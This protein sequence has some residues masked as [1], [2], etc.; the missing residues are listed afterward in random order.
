MATRGYRCV[1]SIAA[2]DDSVTPDAV[3]A[4]LGAMGSAT[5]LELARRGVNV[6]GIDRYAPPH[7]FGSS[8]GKSRIIREAYFEDPRYVPLVQRAYERWTELEAES[9]VKLLHRT[10]GLML[11]PPDGTLVRG[12]RLSA[13]RHKLPHEVLSAADVRRRVP[14]FEPRGDMVGVWEPRA[15]AL[16]PELAIET[17]LKLAARRGAVVHTNEQVMSWKP[18]ALGVEVTTNRATYTAGRLILC[19]GAWTSALASSLKLPLT[20]ERNAVL[21][22]SPVRAAEAFAPERFPIFICESSPDWMWYGFPDLGDGVKVAVHH[23][24]QRC[25]PES[26]DRRVAPEEIERVRWALDKY[27]PAA[28]GALIDTTVCLY[29]NTPDGHFILDTHPESPAVILA[30]PCSGHGFKFAPVIGEILA[31]LAMDQPPRFDISGFALSRFR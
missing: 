2:P 22:F 5:L 15:G 24:G 28:N 16:V 17:M 26:V 8:H 13:Q 23:H 1:L 11:G 19:V 9:A 27:L 20:I 10:G 29:T 30:S 25:D 7:E 12:A 18:T 4:G 14:V 6:V 3:V 31:D 21:W